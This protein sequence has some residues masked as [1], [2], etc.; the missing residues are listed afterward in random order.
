MQVKLVLAAIGTSEDRKVPASQVAAAHE[1]R[2]HAFKYCRGLELD[3][4]SVGT[5]A[6]NRECCLKYFYHVSPVP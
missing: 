1:E 4:N 6:R 5:R 3:Q 2:R